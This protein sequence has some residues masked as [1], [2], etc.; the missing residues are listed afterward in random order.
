MA[1]PFQPKFV[2]LVR[3]TTTTQG[4][5]NFVLGAAATGFT[6][7]TT[8]LQP[9]DSFYYSAIG[10]DKPAEREVGRGTLQANG[11]ISRS[12]ISGS[13]TN[14]SN[15][16]KTVALI[17]AAEWYGAAQ[18]IVAAA[19]RM[20]A[21][22]AD[23][24]A[25]AAYSASPTA[26]LREAGREGMFGWNPSNLSA[27][28]AA[29]SRQ[30]L[31]VAPASDPTGASGAW[32]RNYSGSVNVRWF[33]AVGDGTANDGAAFVGALA[34]LKSFADNPSGGGFYKGSPK[35]FIPAGHYYLGATPIDVRHTL[36]IEGEGSGQFGPG[37]GGCS[38]L[39]WADGTDGLRIQAAN[40]SALST[41]D[42]T[43]H[44]G[45]GGVVLRDLCLEG[46]YAGTESD[47][48]GLTIRNAIKAD[49]LY[50]KNWP[51]EGVKAW[52]G[53]INGFG[54]VSGN[55]STTMLTAVKVEGCRGGIDIRGSDANVVTTINCEGYQNRQFGLI[56]DNGAG[57]NTHIGLHTA[58]N[59]LISNTGVYTQC[60]T[61]GNRYALTWGG[62][63]L[64]GPTGTPD[65]N[66][67]WL[68]VEAGAVVD[69]LIPAWAATAGLFRAGGDILTL[70]S[71]GTVLVN[72]YSEYGGFSQFSANTLIDSGTLL[73]KYHRGGIQIMPDSDY[74]LTLKRWL[75]NMI[76][77]DTGGYSAGFWARDIRN[78]VPFGYFLFAKGGG[79]YFNSTTGLENRVG[80]VP[81]NWLDGGGLRLDT[82]QAIQIAGQQVVGARQ[83]GTPG[84][85][86]DLASAVTLV[87]SLKAKLVAHGLIA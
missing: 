84:D 20:P 65:D 17:A 48:H 77:L 11:S 51:G 75:D 82:G 7:F 73:P 74:G 10:V 72:C 86:T 55:V 6:S 83:T 9:G 79:V 2:D 25:L 52:A 26:Y 57:S 76:V 16:T 56:D 50:I 59:G 3:N 36:I 27:S 38:H 62:N 29:D 8:A 34:A 80:G 67:D 61:G 37:S 24:T 81:K 42:S 30:G 23:R 41:V 85:A 63:P 46:G 58:S 21:I 47:H 60:S 70:N 18:Q 31:F 87:N 22:V 43:V 78:A 39:R 35:L 15:G 13:P 54:S 19:A 5:G 40:T 71:A 64:N 28:V 1:D 45:A 44:D 32:V 66:A 49:R 4:T 14:F 69:N 33:G 68:F 53:T 12:P